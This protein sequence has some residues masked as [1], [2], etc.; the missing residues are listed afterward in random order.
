MNKN[1][2]TTIFKGVWE[3]DVVSFLGKKICFSFPDIPRQKIFNIDKQ[4]EDN[5]YHKMIVPIIE[6]KFSSDLYVY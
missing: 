2:Y 6:I 5:E 3:T 1:D 4:E